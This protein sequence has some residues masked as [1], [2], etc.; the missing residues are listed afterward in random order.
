MKREEQIAD[1]AVQF[2][3]A[4][5]DGQNTGKAASMRG[6]LYSAFK[7]GARWADAHPN[8]ISVE[9][10]LPTEKG[11]YWCCDDDNET[12]ELF[13]DGHSWRGE[14]DTY[15][16]EGITHWMLLPKAPGK[17]EKK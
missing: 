7:A 17:E 5:T 8:W 3:I 9:D 4:E 1:T 15:A 2:A 12:G 6:V 10:E 16:V 13:W 14:I 11:R